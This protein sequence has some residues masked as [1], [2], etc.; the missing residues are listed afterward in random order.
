MTSSSA[1]K[2]RKAKRRKSWTEQQSTFVFRLT[3]FVVGAILRLWVRHYR[4]TGMEH[5]PA[6]GG[7][8]L[9]ANHTSGMDPFLLGYPVCRRMPRG[10][11]KVELFEN[12]F[13]GFIM[14]KIGMFP[15]RQDVADAAAVRTMVELYRNGRVVLIYPEGGRSKTGALQPFFPEFTR[16]MIRLKAPMVPAGIAGAAT[17]LPIGSYIPQPNRRVAIVYGE[18]FDLS[19]FYGQPLTSETLAR[20]TTVLQDRVAEQVALAERERATL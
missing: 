15:L 19:D 3:C 5:V 16:L 12:P 4:A 9:I 10:P 6:S 11:G 18:L 8:F 17:V 2:T 7:L 1:E 13:F 14:R 20:A